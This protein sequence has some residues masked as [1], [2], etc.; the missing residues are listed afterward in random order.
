VEL[1]EEVS[2]MKRFIPDK[3]F[4]KDV[5]L[6]GWDQDRLTRIHIEMLIVELAPRLSISAA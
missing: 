3:S 1:K 6:G 5:D 2:R 4:A